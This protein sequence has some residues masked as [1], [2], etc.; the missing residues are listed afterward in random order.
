[1]RHTTEL[2]SH[3][4]T[5][6][7]AATMSSHAQNKALESHEDAVLLKRY[8]ER[9][10]KDAM[11]ELFKRYA[12]MAYRVSLAYTRNAADAEEAAQS[13]FV[14]ILEGGGK[15]VRNVRGWIMSIVVDTCLN[16][17][18]AEGRRRRREEAAAKAQADAPARA[19][20]DSEKVVAAINAV[21]ALPET[22]RMPVWLHHLEG[23]SFAEVGHALSLPEATVR[24]Q[25]HRGIEQV[26]QAL[27]AA[28]AIGMAAVPEIL[29]AF[30]LPAAPAS[31][32]A[33]IKGLVANHAAT[34]SLM[35]ATAGAPAK[36][37]AAA[38]PAKLALTAG[39]LLAV[40]A[41]V[42]IANHYA[43]GRPESK[44]E[45]VTPPPAVKEL[46]VKADGSGDFPSIQAF[47][48][49]A[50]PGDTCVVH[51]G[52]YNERVAVAHS[53]AEG[54]PITFKTS[55]KVTMQGFEVAKQNYIVMDG[56]EITGKK[57]LPGVSLLSSRGSTI[58]N[59]H[60]H[61]S[62]CGILMK[63][64]DDLNITHNEIDHVSGIG[65]SMKNDKSPSENVFIQENS[66]SYTGWEATPSAAL[67]LAFGK[68]FLVERNDFSHHVGDFITTW[69]G[70][71]VVIRNNVFHDVLANE[72]DKG[73]HIDGIQGCS[74]HVLI[75]GNKMYNC[76]EKGFNV[77]FA[78][79]EQDDRQKVFPSHV[80]LRYNVVSDI[81]SCFLA[82]QH[83]FPQ[84]R[85]YNNTVVKTNGAAG[86]DKNSCAVAIWNGGSGVVI[87]NLFY[88]A[89]GNN[90]NLYLLNK[91]NAAATA[92]DYNLG[93]DSRGEGAW[94]PEYA[95]PAATDSHGLRDKDPLFRAYSDDGN[96]ANDD[97]S[98]QD[99]SPARG[100][101]GAMTTVVEA[102]EKATTIK[103]ADARFFQAGW[104]G[105]QADWIA[106]GD[107]GNIAQV[108]SIDYE[109]NVI[110]LVESLSKAVPPGSPVFLFKKSD[111]ERV[112]HGNRPDIGAFQRK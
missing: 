61:H 37:A 72:S 30:E 56:F 8:F 42:V 98:L 17:M 12:D 35:S 22:Y 21:H 73:P 39:A 107:A 55:G 99:N 38:M 34:G 65:I 41:V 102:G 62:G 109:G 13:A 97:F 57:D 91:G 18:R 108:K 29:A 11:E 49:A 93:F 63:D 80:M 78:L 69:N 60:I 24:K 110:T 100:V 106:V 88:N 53:G 86:I 16:N 1:M 90:R 47:A 32:A 9:G 31:F 14:K 36:A 10:D 77:H 33:S 6:I 26:R 85:A 23:L 54:K 94:N 95:V 76:H 44:E 71:Y 79:F 43:G 68:N 96:Y 5:E 4:L 84:V 105:V 15:D 45:G 75:E 101:G 27:T 59:N 92:L 52:A 87:N 74:S 58:S 48:N 67:A 3:G 2:P 103:V 66:I 28:G 64:V 112:L 104:A 50:K 46:T 20:E 40:S 83:N 70:E 25:A 111:G 51:A 81:D 89:T 7:K 82:V 19:E